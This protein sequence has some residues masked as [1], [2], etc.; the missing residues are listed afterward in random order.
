MFH[1]DMEISEY[2]IFALHSPLHDVEKSGITALA[3][4]CEVAFY[5]S[6]TLL[7]TVW[8]E[9]GNV[10]AIVYLLLCGFCSEGFPLPLGAWHI[11]LCYLIVALSG[12]S[13]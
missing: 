6:G 7:T 3:N 9:R 11:R 4:D 13:I 2:V 1:T 10:S 5:K 8:E 12:H